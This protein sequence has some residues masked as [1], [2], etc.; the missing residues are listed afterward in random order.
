MVHW[1]RF[2]STAR[3]SSSLCGNTSRSRTT[4]ATSPICW[5]RCT[6]NAPPA[7]GR[8]PNTVPNVGRGFVQLTW[9]DNYRRATDDLNRHDERNLVDHP[10]MAL[11]SLIATRVMFRGMAQGW[12]TGRKLDQY[13]NDTKD[14]PVNARQIIN[15]N[16]CDDE[17]AAYHR[18]FLAALDAARIEE[19]VA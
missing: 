13:F 17:I 14:D 15:G 5:R 4:F 19:A 3:T 2:R 6:R 11:D 7:S 9:E 12:F 10:E 18:K 8:S 1:N 16:D